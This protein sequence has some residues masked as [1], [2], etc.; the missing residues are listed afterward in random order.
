MKNTH[1]NPRAITRK[2][3]SNPAAYWRRLCRVGETP[4][5]LCGDLPHDDASAE[6]QLSEWVDEGITAIVDV[7]CEHNDASRVKRLHP[8]I[9]YIWNGVDDA[10]GMQSFDWF[11]DVVDRVLL[12]LKNS[13]AKVVVHCHMGINRGP[14]MAFAILLALGWEPMAALDAIRA[15]RPIAGIIYAD[16]ALHWWHAQ[17]GSDEATLVRD[18]EQL[19]LWQYENDIK[20]DV[21]WVISRIRLAEDAAA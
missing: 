13:Q 9:N 21:P 10:G 20:G 18:L 3:I 19:F 11:D 7:R 12:H 1:Q 2:P 16:S 17:K 6:A 5:Y 14:S 8:H 15:S 4:I